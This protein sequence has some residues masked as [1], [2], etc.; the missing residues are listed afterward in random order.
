MN[1]FIP[2]DQSWS[3]KFFEFNKV[4]ISKIDNFFVF[5]EEFYRSAMLYV[6]AHI[7]YRYGLS[8]VE[9]NNM[10]NE[11]MQICHLCEPLGAKI[12]EAYRR[13]YHD[14]RVAYNSLQGPIRKTSPIADHVGTL[15]GIVFDVD[16]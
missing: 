6:T 12:Q 2:I 14:Y 10:I 3:F 16:Y 9:F 15:Q 13:L 5:V 8:P 4:E 1:V 11:S 7:N